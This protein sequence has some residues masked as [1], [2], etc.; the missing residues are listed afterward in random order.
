MPECEVLGFDYGVG[1]MIEA[2][3]YDGIGSI[4]ELEVTRFGE[5]GGGDAAVGGAGIPYDGAGGVGEAE[6]SIGFETERAAGVYGSSVPYRDSAGVSDGGEE[7][8]GVAGIGEE[9]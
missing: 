2:L 6:V 5:R 8:G 3:P 1:G 7:E 4:S 9:D